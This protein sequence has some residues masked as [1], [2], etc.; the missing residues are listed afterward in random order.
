MEDIDIAKKII[1]LLGGDSGLAELKAKH[2]HTVPHG[3]QFV[4]ARENPGHATV[5]VTLS[6]ERYDVVV[7][8][9]LLVHGMQ[10]FKAL[11]DWE[12]AELFRTIKWAAK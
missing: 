6:L 2:I 12:L 8:G 1:A 11:Q 4:L 5:K 7:D 10:S 3:V 9:P